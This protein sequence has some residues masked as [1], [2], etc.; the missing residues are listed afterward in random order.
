M[1]AWEGELSCQGAREVGAAAARRP[2]QRKR[3]RSLCGKGGCGLGVCYSGGGDGRETALALATGGCKG[4]TPGRRLLPGVA[5]LADV[6]RQWSHVTL[7]ISIPYAL[8]SGFTGN[9][10]AAGRE[11]FLSKL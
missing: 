2:H 11:I 3:R 7:I 5:V 9:C 1:W 8:K 4:A 10:F 6:Q